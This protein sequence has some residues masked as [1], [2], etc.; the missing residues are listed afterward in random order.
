MCREN[1]DLDDSA[2]VGVCYVAHKEVDIMFTC[3]LNGD[4]CQFGK[5]D[6]LGG[7]GR[8]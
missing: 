8:D 7:S 2:F 6:N 4:I 1:A 5:G 3:D